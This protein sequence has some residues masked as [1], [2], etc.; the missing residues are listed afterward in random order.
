MFAYIKTDF[1][2]T[3]KQT[4][5]DSNNNKRQL[6]KRGDFKR[7]LL[8]NSVVQSH[9]INGCSGLLLLQFLA[10]VRCCGECCAQRLQMF[11]ANTT[12]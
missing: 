6:R 10:L 3:N 1:K 4:N 12:R 5:N 8:L 7:A 2:Q 9:N 11:S